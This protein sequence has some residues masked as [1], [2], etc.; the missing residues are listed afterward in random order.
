MLTRA[1]HLTHKSEFA[2][3]KPVFADTITCTLS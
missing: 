2:L 1:M 3:G